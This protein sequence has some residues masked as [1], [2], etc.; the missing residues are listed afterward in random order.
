MPRI[1]SLAAATPRSPSH[2]NETTNG[3]A[4]RQIGNL[5]L[6]WFGYP[7]IGAL[8]AAMIIGRLTNLVVGPDSYKIYIVGNIDEP[9]T[10]EMVDAFYQPASLPKLNRVP[11]EIVKMDDNGDP[12]EAER[13]SKDL[14]ARNDTLM[15]VGHLQSTPTQRAIPA[16]MQANP[17]I[18]VIL[19]TET[20]PYLVPQ[21][22]AE[23]T[24]Y[25]V[26]RL[27]ATDLDQ[28]KKAA[29]F[30]VG[31]Q[32]SKFWVVEDMGNPV[33]SSYLAH[34][35]VKQLDQPK[36]KVLLWSS[37]YNIPPAYAIESLGIDWVFFAGEWQNGLILV[38]QLR[39]MP[40]TKNVNVL[41]SDWCVDE[42]LLQYGDKDVEGVYLTHPLPANVYREQQYRS[43][44]TDA[45]SVIR[46]LLQEGDQ[47][48]NQVATAEGR[49]T[50]LTHRLLGL[51]RISDARRVIIHLMQSAVNEKTAFELSGG[52]KAVF[53]GNS[54]RADSDFEVWQILNQQF[55][56]AQ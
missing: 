15:V 22:S 43:Y 56:P 27:T 47:K 30:A 2:S 44:G 24:F 41:L 3:R 39:A 29:A 46:Q 8:I 54:T 10:R 49:L 19:T 34:E 18:P 17:A 36:S 51:R 53:N 14:V 45:L 38:R 11:V 35:F 6:R 37:N 33:Y 7:L 42:R 55:M 52:K 13:I 16:Y 25:P 48:F 31:K 20:N 26:F 50:Y 21:P 28:A 23:R 12:D 32:A 4:I 1:Q 5:L 40:K 9:G